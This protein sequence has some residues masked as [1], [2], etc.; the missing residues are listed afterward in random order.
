[1]KLKLNVAGRIAKSVPE[2]FEAVVDPSQLSRY[3]TTGGAKE[4]LE[5]GATVF[6]KFHELP[7]ALPV[8][9]VEVEKN[10][11]IVF[12][13]EADDETP[14][15]GETQAAPASYNTTVTM[16][17]EQLDDGRTLVSIS[18][19]GWHETA[20]GL[21]ASYENCEGWM[22]ALCSLKAYLEYGINL[23]DGMFKFQADSVPQSGLN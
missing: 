6:W 14:A 20:S 5:T 17:F 11:R 21:E 3:F 19:E 13:W 23:R 16:S 22:Q 1:M 9:V 10:R 18:E 8:E 12:R 2:V 4:R 7:D 15:D